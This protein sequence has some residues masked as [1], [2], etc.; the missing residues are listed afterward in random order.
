M[1]A[2]QE[3]YE[4]H[5]AAMAGLKV[6]KRTRESA[7]T[8][9]LHPFRNT[10]FHAM[11]PEQVYLRVEQAGKELEET[12]VLSLY[13]AFESSLRSH[14]C[15]A[16][17]PSLTGPALR[18]E[19]DVRLTGAIRSWIDEELSMDKVISLFE[20]SVGV[21]A[22]AR[23]GTVRKFRHWVAHGRRSTK[24][25]PD[26]SPKFAYEVLSTFLTRAQLLPQ[27]DS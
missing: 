26:V 7:T 21:E 20:S 19:E 11:K 18:H 1:S 15:T 5:L 12:A 3:V 4:V 23:V 6:V 14:I 9:D 2:I 22:L 16:L 17:L 10:Y 8:D 13:A 24:R 27:A 25:P